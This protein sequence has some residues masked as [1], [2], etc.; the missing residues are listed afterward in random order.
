MEL[1]EWSFVSLNKCMEDP[2]C[3]FDG[4]QKLNKPS[5][6]LHCVHHFFSW[7]FLSPLYSGMPHQEMDP[8]I[9]CC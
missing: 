3:T 5:P 9:F 6:R 7:I 1:L 8:M 2:F 4:N